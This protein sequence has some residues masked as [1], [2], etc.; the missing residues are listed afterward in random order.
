M[1]NL[2][3]SQKK[4]ENNNTSELFKSKTTEINADLNDKKKCIK[5]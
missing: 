3:K 1:H 5:Y 4:K 2:M